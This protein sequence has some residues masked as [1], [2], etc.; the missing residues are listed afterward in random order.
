MRCQLSAAR[1]SKRVRSDVVS[2]CGRGPMYTSKLVAQ[3][4]LDTFLLQPEK[5]AEKN[6]NSQKYSCA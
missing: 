6:L 5:I 2:K 4:L 1:K 3:P